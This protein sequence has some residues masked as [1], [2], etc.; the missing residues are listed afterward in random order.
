MGWNRFNFRTTHYSLLS[1]PAKQVYK[2]YEAVRTHLN[3]DNLEAQLRQKE[4]GS[5]GKLNLW[6]ASSKY[7]GCKQASFKD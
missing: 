7:D 6:Y 2:A 1:S 3:D 5:V 4:R